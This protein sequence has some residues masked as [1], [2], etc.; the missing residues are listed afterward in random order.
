[1]EATTEQSAAELEAKIMEAPVQEAPVMSQ[2][3]TIETAQEQPLTIPEKFRGKGI[4]DVLKSY[5][6]LEGEHTRTR[7]KMSELETKAARAEQL[8]AALAQ[9][10]MQMQMPV[11]SSPV[12]STTLPAEDFIQEWERDPARAV[13][14]RTERAEK[15]M[16][17][18]LNAM[19]TSR[20][21]H[22]VKSKLPDFAELEPLMVSYATQMANLVG[23][24]KMNNPQV[25]DALYY[26]ARGATV[27]QRTQQAQKQGMVEAQKLQREKMS[28]F[29]EGATPPQGSVRPEDLSASELEKLIGVVKR[30]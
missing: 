3:S 24:E 12:Q 19:N 29:S 11:Q 21:Y 10:Q 2:E 7:Q 6:H 9:Q 13:L 14:N 26:M 8:E 27:D 25:I 1:M 22:D 23:P 4:E 18:M 17:N 20:Y 30:Y 16:E 28:A 5:T 15:K